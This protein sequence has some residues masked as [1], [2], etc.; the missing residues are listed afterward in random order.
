MRL[1]LSSLFVFMLAAPTIAAG[2]NTKV[3]HKLYITNSA[4]DD[5]TVVDTATNKQIGRIIVGKSP[6][7][8]A[9]P[10]APGLYPRLHRKRQERRIGLDRSED[11]PGHQAHGYRPG[12]EPARRHAGR[13]ICLRAG[14]RW[15]LGS[16]RCGQGGDRRGAS[17]RAADRT[18]RFVRWTAS[19]CTSLPWAPQRR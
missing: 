6:H 2:E 17:S 13:Q 11:R 16:D 15:L 10:E 3:R 4:G 9:V 18:T 19:T 1:L 12:A 14:Q 5:V 7:G 8:I